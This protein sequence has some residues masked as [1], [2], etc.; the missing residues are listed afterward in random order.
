MDQRIAGI[1]V[2]VDYKHAL[3]DRGTMKEKNEYKIYYNIIYMSSVALNILNMLVILKMIGVSFA[4]DVYSMAISIVSVLNLIIMMFHEQFPVYFS[5]SLDKRNFYILSILINKLIQLII[6]IL[7]MVFLSQIINIFVNT[8]SMIDRTLLRRYIFYMLVS[9]I[10][11]PTNGFSYK[12]FSVEKRYLESVLVQSISSFIVTILLFIMI[13][14][15]KF[16]ILLFLKY[17]MVLNIFTGLVVF[18]V[19]RWMLVG[20]RKRRIISESKPVLKMIIN[21][22]KVKSSSSLYTIIINPIVSREL[23]TYREG[24]ITIYSYAKK[25]ADIIYSISVGSYFNIVYSKMLESPPLEKLNSVVKSFYKACFKNSLVF[26]VLGTLASP[27][28]YVVF[29]SSNQNIGLLVYLGIFILSLVWGNVMILEN[30]YSIMQSI[31][32]KSTAFI[33]ANILNIIVV[34]LALRFFSVLNVYKIPLAL[35]IGQI[36]SF[37]IFYF[38]HARSI[39]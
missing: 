12:V 8:S 35:G 25:S 20:D 31:K 14:G 39:R 4:S 17:S 30:P 2:Q 33:L 18:L 16:N 23:S 34:Y 22:L 11:N 7:A 28:V 15:K 38:S 9:Q 32:K 21:S 10:F 19:T 1:Y 24:I 26:I 13:A 36:S 5:E 27:V 6:T 3:N 29:L 37:I